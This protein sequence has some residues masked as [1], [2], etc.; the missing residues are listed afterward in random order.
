[1]EIE[2]RVYFRRIIYRVIDKVEWTDNESFA[3][4]KVSKERI[5]TAEKGYHDEEGNDHIE[6]ISILHEE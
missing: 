4:G 3:E 2:E 6:E 1:M 5:V